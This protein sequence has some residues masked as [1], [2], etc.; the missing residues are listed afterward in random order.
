MTS[1]PHSRAGLVRQRKANRPCV[2]QSRFQLCAGLTSTYDVGQLSSSHHLHISAE[3]SA[4]TCLA[5]SLVRADRRW[6]FPVLAVLSGSSLVLYKSGP[7]VGQRTVSDNEQF[8]SLSFVVARISSISNPP[9]H[10]TM[11]S[12]SATRTVLISGANQ[13]IGFHT[14]AAFVQQPG[15]HVLVCA[16][17][18]EKVSEA[19]S[20]IAGNAHAD[21]KIT[22]IVLDVT[23]DESIAAVTEQVRKL[24]GGKLDV[25][26]NN[27]GVA[28]DNLF[29]SSLPP[30]KNR[31]REAMHK[32]F[33]VNVFGVAALSEALFPLL[34]AAAP[35]RRP[36][37]VN[38]SSQLASL[39]EQLDP[40]SL[41]GKHKWIAYGPSKTALS[42]IT[43]MFA[44]RLGN[45]GRVVAVC[46]GE[47]FGYVV[48]RASSASIETHSYEYISHETGYTSTNLNR[49]NGTGDPKDAG[50]W[51]TQVALDDKGETRA[52]FNKDGP[53]RW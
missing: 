17:T 13:G 33:D 10:V 19:V 14:A 16:R 29:D 26:I 7:V 21:T 41:F 53:L 1:S 49:Y 31:L 15:W 44:N 23:D 24:T 9:P 34:E 38:V 52:F 4:S 25:L 3:K 51:V 47:S 46:P 20:K 36:V 48:K 22:S 5:L 37:V 12:S 28:S 30:N 32:T 40:D 42:H 39:Q 35:E 43:L 8:R 2:I 18:Q 11:S 27:A 50:A 6:C 45:K